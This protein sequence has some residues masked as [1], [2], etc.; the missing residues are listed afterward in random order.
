MASDD[1]ESAQGSGNLE[2]LR[3]IEELQRGVQVE[4]NSQRLFETYYGWVRSFFVRRKLPLDRA[5]DLSQETFFRVFQNIGSFRF[6]GTFESWLFAIAA[7]LLR[8]EK[9]YRAQLKRSAT[10]VSIEDSEET[11]SPELVDREILPEERALR[12]ERMEALERAIEKLPEKP[13]DCVRLR[14]AGRDYAA[15]AEILRLSTSTAR[16]HIYTARQRLQQEFGEE[17]GSWLK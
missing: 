8:H 17:L 4:R 11:P 12:R 5:E 9:R 16:V 7:N 1:Q 15:I 6:D 14:L 3:W 10:E 2:A 13:R